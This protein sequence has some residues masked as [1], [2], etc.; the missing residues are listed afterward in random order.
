MATSPRMRWPYPAE[1]VDPWYDSFEGM[2]S[3]QDSSVFGLEE[4]KNVILSGG[5]IISWDAASGLLQWANSFVLN[6]SST[7]FLEEIEAGSAYL[8]NDGDVLYVRFI[9]GPSDNVILV[10]RV[11]G[12]LPAAD[13]ERTLVI[14]RRSGSRIF[15]RNGAVLQDGESAAV[16]D[17]GTSGVATLDFERNYVGFG[18]APTLNFTGP[19]AVSGSVAAGVASV[20]FQMAADAV[21]VTVTPYT[22]NPAY[23]AFYVNRASP[24]TVQLPSAASLPQQFIVIKTLTSAGV[25]VLPNGTETID[26]S[27]SMALNSAFDSVVLHATTLDGVNWLWFRAASFGTGGGGGGASV[28][29]LTK[30]EVIAVGQAVRVNGAGNAIL[31]DSTVAGRYPA[32]GICV[33]SVGATAVI[34]TSGP[35]TA[36]SGLTIGATYFLGASGNLVT[37]PPV[38][39]RA[40][41]TAVRAYSATSGVI[42]IENDPI[43]LI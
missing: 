35:A 14:C 20:D 15:F 28:F 2:V 13:L 37:T 30:A 10:A 29:T 8:N 12:A 9:N 36:F 27:I 16:I 1:G 11:T 6:A 39:A 43:Y 42:V 34:Q 31:A 33:S 3:A 17:V 24:T 26:G 22:L 40:S 7:G 5:G 38:G 41:Q 25:T 19:M 23:R 4:A 21:E 18:S 32:L